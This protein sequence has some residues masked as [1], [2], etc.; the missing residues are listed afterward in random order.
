MKSFGVW[1][2]VVVVVRRLAVRWVM[3]MVL[4]RVATGAKVLVR[5]SRIREVGE[6]RR[7][8]I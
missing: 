8:S 3:L 6:A 2:A 1:G 4:E 5:L 7:G